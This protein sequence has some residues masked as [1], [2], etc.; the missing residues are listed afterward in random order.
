MTGTSCATLLDVCVR[1]CV[2]LVTSGYPPNGYPASH[3]YPHPQRLMGPLPAPIP[4]PQFG[5]PGIPHHR[6]QQI[7]YH[8]TPMQQQ[9]LM[10]EVVFKKKGRG[11]AKASASRID[12]ES[13]TVAQMP[14]YSEEDSPLSCGWIRTIITVRNK[15]ICGRRHD[16]RHV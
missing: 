4:V 2:R 1:L 9:Q 16:G 7:V 11:K 3:Q 12:E 15:I 13:I 14:G 5:Q 6:Q 8:G 10:H